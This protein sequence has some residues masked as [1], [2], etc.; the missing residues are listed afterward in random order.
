MGAYRRKQL[1]AIPHRHKSFFK[2]LNVRAAKRVA[3]HCQ[4]VTSKKRTL[5][6][7]AVRVRVSRELF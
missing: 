5:V 3:P 6:A 2:V 7:V 1:P 4:A